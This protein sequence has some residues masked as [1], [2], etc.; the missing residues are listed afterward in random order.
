[1]F[2]ASPLPALAGGVAFEGRSYMTVKPE[3]AGVMIP[4]RAPTRMTL[5]A[6]KHYLLPGAP[7]D[8]VPDW[9]LEFHATCE[10][11]LQIGFAHVKAVVAKV[12]EVYT[13]GL[14]ANSATVQTSR[15][16]DFEAGELI[17]YYIRGT[18]SIA[19]D[20]IVL[21]HTVV[22]Q[23]ANQARYESSRVKL[24]NVVCPFERYVEP[25][26]SAYFDLLAGPGQLP[27]GPRLAC[28]TVAHDQVGT[29]AGAWF[30][31]PDPASGVYGAAPRGSYGSPLSAFRGE[32]GVVYLA[33]LNNTSLRIQPGNPTHR[34]PRTV[35]G[36]HC[37]Q[38]YPTP[39]APDGYVMVK[40]VS[41]TQM[42]VAHSPTGACP[43]AF[44]AS[45]ETYYR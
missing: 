21:D 9:A 34:D 32:D 33:G 6:A 31:N 10:P 13:A 12:Q 35:T 24:L 44:P 28:G 37:Y 8:Y 40:L 27:G 15:P 20:F 26:R 11:T 38:D 42:Q 23:F 29:A 14:V 36:E 22:N 2:S 39:S 1:L 25:L 30:L 5:Y 41:A 18:N 19:W 45:F 17:G 16:V 7:P 43:P 3:Q 4:I